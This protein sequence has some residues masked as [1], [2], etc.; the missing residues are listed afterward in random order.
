MEHHLS[1]RPKQGQ[2][3]GPRDVAVI[4]T[5]R[6]PTENP[7]ACVAALCHD[8]APPA[9]L[10]VA[11]A[12]EAPALAAFDGI[13][14]LP[15]TNPIA[16]RNA[17]A[18]A[19][20]A[21]ILCFID[22]TCVPAPGWINALCEPF[23]DPSVVGCKGAYATHLD[24]LVPR[25]VQLEYEEKYARLQRQPTIDFIDTYSAAYRRD[26]LLA[27]GSFDANLPLLEDQELSF[28]LAARGYTMVFRPNARVFLNQGATVRSYVANKLAIGFWKAQVVRRFPPQG[29]RDSHTPQ[30]VKLQLVLLAL[31]VPALGVVAVTPWG[32]TA[33]W[34]LF[35]ALLLSMAPF[36][37]WAAPR[38]W[39]AALI[40]PPMLLLR[41]GAL[42]VGYTWGVFRP[43]P[44]ISGAQ[45]TI[46]GRQYVAKRVLDIIGGAIG[47][48]L[49]AL[50]GPWVA[51]G[52]KLDSPGP[53]LFRQERIG[54][55]G[56]PFT[57]FKFR[58]MVADAEARLPDLVDLDALEEPVFKLEAD[59]RVTRFGRFLRRWSL[60]ELPQFW[61]V[62]RGQMSLV[63][64]RPEEKRMVDR[65]NDW[66][67]RR[68]VVKPGISGPMQIGGRANLSL[69]QRV[70][71]ELAYIEQYSLRHDLHILLR[72][73]PA[74]LRG[75]G[76]R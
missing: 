2:Q 63:G 73:V 14:I 19:A 57:M 74:V 15:D 52:I 6:R 50:V 62:L 75:D 4:V 54:Q 20:T 48:L 43:K 68:L 72:T 29:V 71:L 11:G 27:N 55:A 28:R 61:N 36:M 17:A 7:V 1:F 30:V 53:I 8:S 67:R 47:V 34:L 66:H 23:D 3:Y 45:T 18:A 35:G 37:V 26:V 12:V 22:A 9:E 31:S 56:L 33:F 51:L 5:A 69:D 13:T 38:D 25:F 16:A 49:L 42:G 39:V 41:A 70:R 58:S 44:G 40:A 60:D 21:P 76:A 32:W 46:G 59:P 10:F 64:P 24:Q 65:Y